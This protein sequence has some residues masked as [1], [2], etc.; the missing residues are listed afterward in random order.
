MNRLS[1]ALLMS[2]AGTLALASGPAAAAKRTAFTA[3]CP[4]GITVV[5]KK[6]GVVRI[7]GK[8]AEV[9]VTNDN[10]YEAK[11]RNITISVTEDD[12]GLSVSYTLKDG[13]NGI[14]TVAGNT[15]A[16]GTTPT[17]DEQACLKAVA[18]ETG[19]A[20][21]AVLGTETSEANTDVTI[22]VGPDRAPWKCLVK[23]GT[24]AEVSS[25]TDEGAM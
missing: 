22:G 20:D 24:V 8:K 13:A 12:S 2:A 25:L 7:N 11:R 4:T 17:P 5:A 6:N 23:D 3:T 21:V 19:N 9:T 18:K 16:T 14:C 10:Y 15:E 1:F